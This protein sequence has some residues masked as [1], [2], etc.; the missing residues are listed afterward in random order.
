M[1]L[2]EL[3]NVR[4]VFKQGEL[5][6]EVL[7]GIDLVIERGEF[8][9]V[10]GPSGSGKSTLMYILGCLDKPTSGEYF[11]DGKNVLEMEDDELSKVRSRYIGFVFQAFYL[12]PYLT[13]LDNVL[14]PVEYLTSEWKK[15]VFSTVSPKERALHLLKRLGM[16]ERID[17]KPDQLSG[18]QKQ[19]TAI[20][21]ALINSPELILADEPTGQL[22]SESG[23]AVMDIFSELN[24]EGKT[25][26]IVTHDEKVASYAKRIVKIRDGKIVG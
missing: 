3:K 10:M 24:E 17:F 7:K 13:V 14:L 25:I 22:D 23:K 12:V 18:G 9:A 15:A 8:L 11:L 2:V 5:E 4:K 21:R 1:P 20:A 16:A 26:V 6:V 19:R